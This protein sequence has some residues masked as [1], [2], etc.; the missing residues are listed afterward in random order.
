M[1]RYSQTDRAFRVE[2][3]SL[4]DDVLLL[5]GFTGEEHVS[6]P[7]EFTLQCLSEETGIDPKKVLREPMILSIRLPDGSDR[8]IHGLCNRFAQQGKDE[9]LTSYEAEIVPWLWFLSLNQDCKIFQEKTVLEI[10]E[11]VF[12]KYGQA[13]FESKCVENY[14]PKEFCVQYRESD[15][16]FVSRLM[17]EEG[18]FYFFQH[19]SEG[20]KLILA[21]DR[22]AV[23]E[24]EGQDIFRVEQSPDARADEDVI[25][26]MEREHQVYTAKVTIT[27][28]D[29]AQPSMN[30]ESSASDEDY[31]EIYDFPGKYSKLSD[32]ERYASL[33]LQERAAAQELVRGVGRCRA[34]RSGYEFDLS[35]HYRADT[36]QTYFLKSIWHSGHGGGYR[37]SQGEVEYSNQFECVPSSIP[38]R[39]ASRTPKPVVQGSQTAVV[40]GPSGEEIFTEKNGQVKVQF[41]W[42]RLGQMDENSSCWVR[43]AHPWAGKGWGAVSIPRIGQEVIVDF[44]EGD[45]DRPII[46]GRVYN[47]EAMPPFPLPDSAVVSGIKSDSHKGSGYNEMSM[48]DT[49]GEEKFTV[50]AQ[51]DESRTVGND[52][53]ESVGNNRSS[54]VSVD[55]SLDVG[56]NQSVSVGSNQTISVSGDRTVSVSGSQTT[57]VSG[58][59]SVTVTGNDSVGTSADHSLDASGAINLTSGAAMAIN[60]GAGLD[61]NASANIKIGAGGTIEIS[62]PGG[63]KLMA[64]GTSIDMTPGSISINGAGMFDVVAGLIKHNG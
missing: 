4:G 37:T 57:E 52:S 63:I 54:S 29:F 40:V 9:D 53:T 13:D 41:H 19:S 10:I 61:A 60:V 31:E 48:N 22:S 56:S 32:G 51:Y 55:D 62:A 23:E 20:H 27:D 36:N 8:E 21:D 11:E 5:E 46:T 3:P 35:E 38:F 1:P 43:P 25:T 18:I 30:L 24:C 45:P 14:S 39:P 33:R 15:L 12:S 7:F 26:E 2:V 50:H 44:L 42:D 34:F 17:E 58:T 16:D 47:A 64:G 59:R 28:Y 6:E 49:P